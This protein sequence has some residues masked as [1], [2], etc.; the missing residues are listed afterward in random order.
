MPTKKV[1][2]YEESPQMGE[3]FRCAK[4][5]CETEWPQP[6]MVEKLMEMLQEEYHEFHSPLPPPKGSENWKSTA[7]RLLYPNTI[8][9]DD[10]FRKRAERHVRDTIKFLQMAQ[11]F[12]AKAEKQPGATIVA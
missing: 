9:I 3:I 1:I 6:E 4:Q 10:A 7:V 5:V 8:K 2:T 11:A 12:A